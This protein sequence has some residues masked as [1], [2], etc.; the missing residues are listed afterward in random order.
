MDFEKKFLFFNDYVLPIP[1]FFV[2]IY[3]WW[4]RVPDNPEFIAFVVGVPTL[5][6]YIVPGIGTN[7][8]GWWRFQGR[9][10]LGKFHTHH[11]FMYGPPMSLIFYIILGDSVDLSAFRIF[12]IVFCLAY[13]LGF[14][15]S[16]HDIMAV[17]NGII[18]ID[19]PPARAGLSPE[20]I[21]NYYGPACFS[22]LGA[23]YG[24]SCA[25]AWQLMVVGK[26]GWTV[27]AWL[28]PVGLA[29]MVFIPALI[30]WKLQQQILV[31]K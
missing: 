23:L 12:S 13:V 17:R 29:L 18:T 19:N 11:G 26:G 25:A 31:D 8:L 3:L 2:M 14:L 20:Q 4:L 27:F 10:M 9:W 5:Y 22:W 21:V 24:G 30:Y 1:L 28:A 16:Q 15:S 7:V 6:G